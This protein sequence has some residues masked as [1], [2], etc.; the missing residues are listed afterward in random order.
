MQAGD[1]ITAVNDKS[2][3]NP[4]DLAVN[5]AGVKPGS[6]A[7]LTVVRDGKT[8]PVD[9]T[10]GTLPSETQTADRGTTGGTEQGQGRIGVALARI[11]PDMR[12]QLNLP[13]GTSGAVVAQVQPNSPADQAGI[14]QGDIIVGVGGHAVSSPT[15]AVKAIREA[16]HSEKDVALRI[17]RDGN[18]AYVAVTLGNGGHSDD[19]TAG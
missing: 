14:R 2:V 17:M 8:Q 13:D 16:S 7:K 5:I 12:D 4:R 9:V 3:A 1:V 18:T 11:T 6:D 19:N 10:V 15:D